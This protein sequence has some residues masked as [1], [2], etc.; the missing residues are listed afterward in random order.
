MR[1]SLTR[2]TPLLLPWLG[3]HDAQVVVRAR[4][5]LHADDFAD[6]AGGRGA[7][8]GGGLHRRHVAGDERR[9]QPAADLVPAEELRR[10]RPSSSRRWL[11][12]GR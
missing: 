2:S 11:R 7:G 6:P 3:Q 1:L 4:N 12:P 8:V 9:D 10:W 5:D